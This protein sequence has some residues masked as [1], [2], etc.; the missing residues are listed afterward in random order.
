MKINMCTNEFN[1]KDIHSND[2]DTQEH[3]DTLNVE[4]PD[5]SGSSDEFGYANDR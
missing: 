5:F 2:V 4:Q 3:D 1:N